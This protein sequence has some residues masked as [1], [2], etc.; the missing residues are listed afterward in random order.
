MLS[1]NPLR[2]ADAAIWSLLESS[3]EFLLMFPSGTQ[4]QVRLVSDDERGSN[5]DLEQ[6]GPADYP[7]V[8]VSL[9]RAMPA[10]ERNSSCSLLTAAYAIEICTGETYQSAALDACWVIYRAMLR[11]KTYVKDVV[12]WNGDP[13]C[14][15]VDAAEIDFTDQNAQRNRQTDQWITVWTTQVF[16]SFSSDDLQLTGS[17]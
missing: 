9:L 2:A 4:R 12:T 10:T 14:Y 1:D 8:R 16:F 6:L 5:P 17:S 7:R 13:C 15:D 11:W 3:P